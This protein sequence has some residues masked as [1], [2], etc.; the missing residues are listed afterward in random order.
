MVVVALVLIAALSFPLRDV[1]YSGISGVVVSSSLLS[2]IVIFCSDALLKLLVLGA[3]ALTITCWF[4]DR[5]P[6]LSL[7]SGG[8]GAGIGYVLSEL[9]KAI[10][11]EER[12]CNSLDVLTAM[13][14][15]ASGDWSWPSNH[16]VV[17]AAIATACTL[18]VPKLAKYAI[19]LAI[20]IGLSR[21]GVGAH[22]F[23]DVVSGLALGTLSVIIAV[24]VLPELLQKLVPARYWVS[25]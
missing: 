10:F 17:A 9:I 11:R 8:I 22:Y 19:P 16:S 1:L 15:P 24:K 18:V 5:P 12:P 14:C 7:A 3:V 25:L 13:A 21:V 20:V 6:F 2:A 23:Q 4:R